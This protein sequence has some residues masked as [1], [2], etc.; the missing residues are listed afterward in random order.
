MCGMCWN[1]DASVILILSLVNW[2]MTSYI[3]NYICTHLFITMYVCLR[4]STQS[5]WQWGSSKQD[6]EI[7][8]VDYVQEILLEDVAQTLEEPE[9][10]TRGSR[11]YYK[12]D[13]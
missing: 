10:I 1:V 13:L 7:C 11:I 9:T 3:H 5:H 6:L 12:F 8:S 2:D 4:L